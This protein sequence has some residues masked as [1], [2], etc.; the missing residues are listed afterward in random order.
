MN[1]P[2]LICAVLELIE[3]DRASG[4]RLAEHLLERSKSLEIHKTIRPILVEV[5]PKTED[6]RRMVVIVQK[7]LDII[8][9]QDT[10]LK[11]LSLVYSAEDHTH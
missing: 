10:W 8:E 1:K 5:E 9:D 3:H 2:K 11:E 4:V 6:E 7:L